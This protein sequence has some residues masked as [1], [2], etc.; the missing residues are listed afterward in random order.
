VS[1]PVAL[2]ILATALLHASWHALVKSSGDQLALLAGMNLVSGIAALAAIPFVA[3]PS[4]DVFAVIA[5][6]VVLHAAY[7][8]ALA[9]LY[10]RADLGRAYPLA[11]GLT[12]I[13]ATLLGVLL[14]HELP[15]ATSLVGIGLISL[16][17]VALVTEKSA[18]LSGAAVLGPAVL[19]GATVAAY[20]VVDAYGVRRSGAWLGY[21]TWLIACDSVAFIGYAFA[22]RGR[23]V[24]AVWS[25]YRWRVLGSGALGLVSF[26][27]F[28]WALSRAPVGAVSALRETSIV[29]S[30][31][32]G[33]LVL[34]ETATWR[35]YTAALLVMLGAAMIAVIR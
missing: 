26:G 23:P 1:P 13:M 8:V 31:L 25:A 6:S 9:S 4:L 24:A 32:L 10:M 35:R 16:G 17:I 18:R 33:A 5:G 19:V 28:L 20:S 14:L 15:G 27:V 29:F 22:V 12:P 3:I 2:A 7:K 11:R 30:A 21:T 34:R